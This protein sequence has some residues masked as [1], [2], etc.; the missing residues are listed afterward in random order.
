MSS[1]CTPV[2]LA[3][4]TR[5]TI[6]HVA[7]RNHMGSCLCI[8]QRHLGHPRHAA[9]VVNRAIL[10]Q[11]PAM[12]MTRVLAQ[13]YIA[14]DDDVRKLF[15]DELRGEDDG[16]LGMVGGGTSCVFSHVER[17]AEEN[18]GLETFGNEWRK[19]RG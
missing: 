13:A 17:H 6:H 12:A 14:C 7:R 8:R 10:P 2:S 16:G 18:H 4:R 11:L 1:A 19:E 5:L 15:A 9:P 3:S